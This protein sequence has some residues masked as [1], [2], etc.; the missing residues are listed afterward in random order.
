MSEVTELSLGFF[1]ESSPSNSYSDDRPPW[2]ESSDTQEVAEEK[3]LEIHR[4]AKNFKKLKLI[5]GNTIGMPVDKY[6]E[7]NFGEEGK[8][9]YKLAKFL[10]EK[11]NFIAS[12]DV[13]L[14]LSCPS[15]ARAII[16]T[17]G[18]GKTTSLH[19]DLIISK[20]MDGILHNYHLEPVKIEDTDVTVPC[21]LYLNYNK[22]NV[23]PIYDK[24]QYLCAQ[25]NKYIQEK[26]NDD[27]ESST[28][29]AFCHKWLSAFSFSTELPEL[30]I[31]TD[32]QKEKV[33]TA[34]IEPRW[35][36]F[37]N[38]ESCRISWQVLE[39][40]YTFKVESMLDWDAFFETAKFVDAG[41]LP[42]FVKS[43]I[44]KYDSMKKQMKVLDFTD[45]LLL[46]IEVLKSN[47]ELRNMVQDRYKIIVADE[48]QDFTALMN[49]LL[50]QLY[51]PK[52]N[53]LI[54]VG[55]PDQT[56]YAFKGVSPDNIVN[57]VGALEDVTV[58][59]LDT[60]YRCPDK[61]VDAAKEI[62]KLN[63]LRFEKPIKTVKTGGEIL[64]HPLE[65][66]VEQVDQVL[67]LL[68]K[69]GPEDYGKTVI[70][71]RNNSSAVIMGEELYYAN[72]PF[73]VLDDRRPFNNMVFR[74]IQNALLA[75]QQKDN[76][77]LNKGLYRFM[78][79]N[80]ELWNNIL[81]QNAKERR[82]YLDDLVLK[83]PL[84][85]G[86]VESFNILKDIGARINSMPCSDYIGV[87]FDLYCKYYFNFI[88]KTATPTVGEQGNLEL[89]LARAKKFWSRPYLFDYM[90]QELSERNRDRPNAVT[91]S[92]FHGLKGLEFDYVIAID[93]EDEVFPNYF[94][95]EQRYSQN[96][97]MEE[98]ESEN[99]LA[100]V[101]VTR[102]IK[103]LHMFYQKED[104]S[105]YV[106]VI[107]NMLSEKKD[108]PVKTMSLGGITLP[109]DA[110][111]AKLNFIQKLTKDRRA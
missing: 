1:D 108:E 62:L 57:L 5:S 98:K 63:I 59:G 23:K 95:I 43:C 18:A 39:E 4:K 89:F 2:E 66:D 52:K 22:H 87:L 68:K 55:D 106:S 105:Y 103:E 109:S 3:E 84:P 10:L 65:T 111:S 79:V 80:K 104:P 42:E 34:V 21:I 78:P 61:I 45:Y 20:M 7:Q 71:Y 28:V 6:I 29:H 54:V 102:A 100:Y 30:K 9:R 99:R 17:A 90:L 75:L 76:L 15:K 36:R 13:L 12:D 91:L 48:N 11:L 8:I 94:S 33:W 64:F 70:C 58:L 27:I 107:Q 14:S 88:A 50:L 37:Y 53:R 25:A 85:S 46:M 73:S 60:N 38:E 81:E 40:L 47:E 44:T 93:F 49:E 56:I 101:L 77:T 35:K 16:A 97:A 31:A 32:D 92:T 26:I 24:H 82:Q 96:T 86:T 74:H 83:Q 69:I 72:I 41:L 19:L 110:R 51:N 67:S